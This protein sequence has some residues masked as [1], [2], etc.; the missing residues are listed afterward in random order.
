VRKIRRK[1]IIGCIEDRLEVRRRLG[2]IAMFGDRDE[3]AKLD[4]LSPS[5]RKIS[6]RFEDLS[7]LNQAL[8]SGG[9]ACGAIWLAVIIS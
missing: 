8:A 5:H 7:R 1:Q 6:A 9:H 4:D 2:E 3:G